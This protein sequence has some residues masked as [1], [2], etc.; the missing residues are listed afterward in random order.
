M[1]WYLFR[2]F[3]VYLQ[4]QTSPK[5]VTGGTWRLPTIKD[6]QYMFIGCGASDS[7]S[8]KGLSFTSCIFAA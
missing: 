2:N 5:K 6:W 7:Y 4:R 1:E 8:D 3:F